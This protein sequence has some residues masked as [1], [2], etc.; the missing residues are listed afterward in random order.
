METLENILNCCNKQAWLCYLRRL[1][2]IEAYTRFPD[3][4]KYFLFNFWYFAGSF[5]PQVKNEKHIQ[6][7]TYCGNF[8]LNSL[9]KGLHINWTG[10]LVNVAHSKHAVPNTNGK[11]I[12]K[13]MRLRS[14]MVCK[15][16]DIYTYQVQLIHLLT[17]LFFH[18][19]IQLLI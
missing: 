10:C 15:V 2:Y 11:S 8:S 14:M 3:I 17:N 4:S 1:C 12:W 13:I 6:L 7:L 5:L 18:S 19:Y 16:L 9:P